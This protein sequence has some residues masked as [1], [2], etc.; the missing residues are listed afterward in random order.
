[1]PAG[2][3]GDGRSFAGRLTGKKADPRDWIFCHYDPRWGNFKPARWV[4]NKRWKLYED[5]RFFDVLSDPRE[6]SPITSRTPEME[7]I[8]VEFQKVLSRLKRA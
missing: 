4:M 2:H 3:P 6:Q 7:R 8:I 1:M 5:G